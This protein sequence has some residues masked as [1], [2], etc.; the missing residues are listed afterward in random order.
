MTAQLDSDGLEVGFCT[1]DPEPM[2]TFYADFLGLELESELAFVGG[3]QW[4]YRAGKSLIKVVVYDEG[5]ERPPVPG[6]GKAQVGIRYI[7][8]VVSNV[9][10]LE[11]KVRRSPYE[12]VEPLTRF[13][14]EI[15]FFFVADP[16]GNW[17]EFAGP[18]PEGEIGPVERD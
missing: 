14:P 12:L 18:V 10:E 7:S 11:E 16:D 15:G 5:P 8:L 17:L 2:K 9:E 3:Y 13:T 1:R 4:R 6:G